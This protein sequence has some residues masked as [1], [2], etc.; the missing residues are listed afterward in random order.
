MAE[1]V[2]A[3]RVARSQ[4][5][6]DLGYHYEALDYAV[7][8]LA[9]NH[10]TLTLT[11][12]VAVTN[13]VVATANETMPAILERLMAAINSNA[14]LMATNGVVYDRLVQ[15]GRGLRAGLR[16]RRLPIRAGQ[17]RPQILVT[18]RLVHRRQGR[19]L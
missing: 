4:G 16:E 13:V 2:W 5:A 1:T 15:A 14:T 9:I 19:Q 7:T 12:G 3:P 6:P 10:A 17:I 11:N 8:D 18:H